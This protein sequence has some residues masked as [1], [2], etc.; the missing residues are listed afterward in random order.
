VFTATT[1]GDAITVIT[2]AAGTGKTTALGTA[3]RI[4]ADSGFTVL[5]LAPSARAAAEL[6]RAT[7]TPAETVAKWLHEQ[8]RQLPR[9]PGQPLVCR[10]LDPRTVLIVDEGS[11]CSTHDLDRI[12]AAGQ[13][14]R[15][16]VVLVGD[17]AQIGVVEGPGGLLSARRPVRGRATDRGAP[18][19]PALGARRLARAAPR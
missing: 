17:P 10:P 1:R 19:Q 3:A 6:G 9:G 8:Q 2:A 13:A 18:V 14:A 4:W 12:T 11:M 15:A 16:K 5:G 7:G